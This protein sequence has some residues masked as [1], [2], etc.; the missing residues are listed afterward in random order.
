MIHKARPNLEL[1]HHILTCDLSIYMWYVK[2]SQDMQIPWESA[3]TLDARK[4]KSQYD[5]GILMA[6][7]KNYVP[8]DPRGFK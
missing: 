2:I 4:G 7:A 8:R 5:K 1:I 6:T 3:K